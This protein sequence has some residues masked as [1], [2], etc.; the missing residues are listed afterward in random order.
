MR[1]GNGGVDVT[2]YATAESR[3]KGGLARAAKI[4]EEKL[5]VRGRLARIAEEEAHSIAGV[6]LEAMRAEDEHG[7]PDHADVLRCAVPTDHRRSDGTR[8]CGDL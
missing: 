6:F 4:R 2:R 3:S 1:T 8:A 5:T 7:R